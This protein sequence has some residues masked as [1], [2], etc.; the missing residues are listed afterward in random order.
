M[1][2]LD[3]FSV[4]D[5]QDLNNNVCS[6]IVNEQSKHNIDMQ[7]SKNPDKDDKGTSVGAGEQSEMKTF[8][9]ILNL[10]RTI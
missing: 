4:L 1:A 2:T 3:I 7:K 5:Q 9:L 8:C 10:Q 6:K